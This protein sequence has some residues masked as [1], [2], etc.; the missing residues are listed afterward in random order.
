MSDPIEKPAHYNQ[1]PGVEVIDLTKWLNFPMGNVVK[2]VARAD[3]KG[4]ALEDLR[5][6]RTY[7][8]IEIAK[9]E[10]G[11]CVTAGQDADKVCNVEQ[12]KEVDAMRMSHDEL[13]NMIAPQECWTVHDADGLDVLPVG[14]ALRDQDGD[15]WRVL[16]SGH[17]LLDEEE[18][19]TPTEIDDDR[20]WLPMEIL[21]P[22]ILGRFDPEVVVEDPLRP[23]DAF[24]H[25]GR[26]VRI[27]D[28]FG[29]GL[30]GRWDN[31]LA[32]VVNWNYG[33]TSA[34]LR[35]LQDRPDRFRRDE[36]TWPREFLAFTDEQPKPAQHDPAVRMEALAHADRA[37]LSLPPTSTG[38]QRVAAV[39]DAVL[40]FLSS[41]KRDE[42]FAKFRDVA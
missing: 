39:V 34:L 3:F 28:R 19:W 21:N 2:Y 25:R 11:Q 31:L 36:F 40:N 27:V 15:A 24:E 7:L 35:P 26:T 20:G 13:F 5:K 22:E 10:S 38:A 32:E 9:R 33:Y 41:G 42:R 37:Y 6:A 4:N 18:V 29:T 12:D 17:L 30:N 23:G 1:F 14:T 16:E 8:D